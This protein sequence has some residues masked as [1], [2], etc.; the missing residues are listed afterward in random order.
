[1][2]HTTE[3]SKIELPF[4]I[5]DINHFLKNIYEIHLSEILTNKEVIHVYFD[6]VS[7][8]PSIS[9]DVGLMHLNK[10]TDPLFSTACIMEALDITLL[11]NLTTLITILVHY[12]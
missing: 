6:V 1:M 11:H 7:M 8:F 9:K 10:R 2:Y 4:V 12:E 3:F 5:K